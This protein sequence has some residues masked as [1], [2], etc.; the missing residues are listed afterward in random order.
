MAIGSVFRDIELARSLEL[1]EKC[2]G[3]GIVVAV[4]LVPVMILSFLDIYLRGVRKRR[5]ADS[6]GEGD[7]SELKFDRKVWAG[8]ACRISRH[9]SRSQTNQTGSKQDAMGVY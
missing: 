5:A 3:N 9:P 8:S 6:I 4:V 1:F 7:P 2:V